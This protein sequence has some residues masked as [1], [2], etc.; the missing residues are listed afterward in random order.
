M[1]HVYMRYT[2][3]WLVCVSAHPVFWLSSSSA[4]G[5]LLE[6]T[7]YVHVHVYG[8]I[9]LRPKAT[10]MCVPW[11]MGC[12]ELLEPGSGGLLMSMVCMAMM[13]GPVKHST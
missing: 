13:S 3:K 10:V 9:G 8:V 4:H 12:R 11:C 1:V 5:H 6:R 2:Y 7:Q